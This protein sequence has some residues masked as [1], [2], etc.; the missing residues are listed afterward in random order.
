MGGIILVFTLAGSMLGGF[1]KENFFIVTTSYLGSFL[2]FRGLGSLVGNYPN[3]L[4]QPAGSAYFMYI[5]LIVLHTVLGVIAQSILKKKMP[6]KDDSAEF[7]NHTE[8]TQPIIEGGD[9]NVNVNDANVGEGGKKEGEGDQPEG[10]GGKKE[11]EGG[12]PE[13]E[14]DQPEGEGDKK[15][16]EGGKPEGEGDQPEGEGDVPAQE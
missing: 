13:G 1:L 5:G 9:A 8:L 10:E 6:A 12:K 15:E 3:V 2:V 11:G 14:G 7:T 4:K 16:G